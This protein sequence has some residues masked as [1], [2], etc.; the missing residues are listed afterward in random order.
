MGDDFMRRV[1][2]GLQEAG[3]RGAGVTELGSLA[4]GL[5]GPAFGPVSFVAVF[6]SAFGIPVDVLQRALA[7]Q[8]FDFGGSVM[9]DEEFTD[10]LSDWIDGFGTRNAN[11][12]AGSC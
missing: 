1:I 11:T 7:W 10:L 4:K 3:H 2:H 6:R 8:G 5:L 9:S 12:G